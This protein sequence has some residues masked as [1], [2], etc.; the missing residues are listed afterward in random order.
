MEQ[1]VESFHDTHV[2]IIWNNII[3]TAFVEQKSECFNLENNWS[4][5]LKSVNVYN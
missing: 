1:F 4:E 3:K 2:G 5:G